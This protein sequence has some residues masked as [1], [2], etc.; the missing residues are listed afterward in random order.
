MKMLELLD[1]LRG[2]GVVLSL[3]AGR[4]K[5][6]APKGAIT[7]A[8]AEG[9]RT[10]R[11]ALVDFLARARVAGAPEP[12]CIPRAV[13]AAL[14][15]LSFA[16]QRLWFIDRLE[17]GSSQYNLP[18]ALELKGR[19]EPDALQHALDALVERHAI[20]RTG[21]EEHE[22]VPMQRVHP[23]GR[24]PLDRLDLRDL[25]GPEGEDALRARMEADAGRPFDLGGD[26]MLRCTLVAMAEAKH[27]LLFTMHHIA[28]DG[29]SMGILVREMAALYAG[30]AQ[31]QAVALA[32]LRIQYADFASW[33]RQHAALD[34]Q[35]D[36]WRT[37]LDGAPT[38][39]ELP[40][41][42][43]RPPVQSHAGGLLPFHLQPALCEALHALSRRHGTSLFMTLLAG[44][45]ALLSRLSGQDEVVVG[46]PV[47]NRQRTEVEPL[48]GFFVN[49]LALRVGFD[50]STT[51]ASLLDQV[52]E[53][54]LEAYAHQDV[55][56]EQVVEAVQPV[57]SL[58]HSPLCQAVLSFNN[59]PDSGRLELPGLTLEAI[60]PEHQSTH[61]D[62]TLALREG[63]D[64]IAG[65]LEFA[66]DLFDEATLRHWL[67]GFASLLEA[68]A[69][70]DPATPVARLP[71]LDAAQRQ[72]LLHG[73]HGASQPL[74]HASVQAA[75]EARVDATPDA[76]ALTGEGRQWT[77]DALDRAA[78]RLAHG[79][80][81]VGVGADVRVA[82]CAPRSA[83]F[84]VAMLAVLKAG[85]A[86]VPLEVDAPAA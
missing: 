59:T 48:I 40:T 18:A 9:I 75:F 64:G 74:P 45:S 5:T 6:A 2:A 72:H 17:G 42:R 68:M 57:R 22:G 54:T 71:F 43:P 50:A 26:L 1:A 46:T 12:A 35:L 37:R 52:R 61:F 8:L 85:A 34:A 20:L 16:Q 55:P 10:H 31:G 81:E 39:L 29:W 24:V 33:Q 23:A 84:V 32:P 4:L 19:F 58:A 11:D 3:E 73:V 79:L 70:A 65:G 67:A 30:F 44:W 14:H 49:T 76:L 15:P 60:P 53:H 80:R 7:P 27:V 21:Y 13:E 82:I 25:A 51:V 77:F 41:D 36:Y 86:Y 56:F 62:L 38:L 69:L 28:S 63:E 78:N 83:G 66:R 47:A